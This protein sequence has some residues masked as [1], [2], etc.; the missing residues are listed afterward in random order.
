MRFA[1]PQVVAM[2]FSQWTA[3]TPASAAATVISAWSF[4]QVQ[5]LTMSRPSLASISL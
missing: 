1:S 3:F 4:I 5:M 2:G